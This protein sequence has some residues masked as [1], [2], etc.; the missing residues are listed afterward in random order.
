MTLPAPRPVEARRAADRVPRRVVDDHSDIVVAQGR[1]AGGVGADQ[2]ARDH[3]SR[4]LPRTARRRWTGWP[5]S[6]C[7]PPGP[8]RRSVLLMAPAARKTPSWAFPR[9]ADAGRRGADAGYPRARSFRAGSAAVPPISMPLERL[10]EIRFPAPAAVP[11]IVLD[12]AESIST[13][14]LPLPTAWVPERSVPIRLPSTELPAAPC[15]K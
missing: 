8:S 5:R 15:R 14:S 3:G 9:G 7:R 11:P 13:P 12:T 4:S 6:G 2:V 1:R 10:A